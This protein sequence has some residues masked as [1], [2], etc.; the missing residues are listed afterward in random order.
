MLYTLRMVAKGDRK[1]VGVINKPLLQFLSA[2]V[3]LFI[4]LPLMQGTE[5]IKYTDII[6][7]KNQ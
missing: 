2:F 4:K 1:N 3:R 5:H 6:F 7:K